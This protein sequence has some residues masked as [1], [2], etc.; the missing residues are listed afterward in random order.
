MAELKTN[1]IYC[2]DNKDILSKLP[3]KSLDLIYA[4]PPFFSNK[5]YEVIWNDGAEIR[6]FE[7]RWEGGI[8]HYIDWMYPRLAECHRVL[9]DT[10]SMYLHCDWH[11]NAH[12]R[13]LMGKIFGD[14]NFQNEIIWCYKGGNATRRFRQK[15]DTIFLYTKTSKYIFNPDTTRI[16]YS[17]KLLTTTELDENGKR[18]YRTGQTKKGKIYLH[19]N[20]QLPYDWWNDIP[21]GTM[22]HGKEFIGYPTQKPEAL[23]K[24]II[25]ASSDKDNVVLDPFCGC[26]TTIKVAK[27]LGRYWIGI[28]VSPTACEL[29]GSRLNLSDSSLI[30]MPTSI[31]HLKTLAPFEFQN[32][33]LKQIDGTVNKKKTSDGGVDGWTFMNHEPVQ[34]KQQEKIGSPKMQQFQSAIRAT[35]QQQGYYYA[36]SFT[37]GAREEVARAKNHDGITIN[38][39][40]IQELL[41]K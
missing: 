40:T 12:L 5:H 33:V 35:G 29:M 11:A 16:P 31:E 27:D 8:E 36:F 25:Q 18:F 14:N 37:S 22:A 3:E 17:N 20:G 34:V 6:S 10:G 28:D 39:I 7:D 13:I 1:V 30:G 19:P 15:H 9:K 32:W 21:S 38:L 2:G 4:D 23:L 41:D 24:R 26:G